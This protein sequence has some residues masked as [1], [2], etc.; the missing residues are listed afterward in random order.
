M[1]SPTS[2]A[3]A[4]P[5][6]PR[7]SW[8]AARRRHGPVVPGSPTSRPST[9][10]WRDVSSGASPTDAAGRPCS[11]GPAAGRPARSPC[12]GSACCSTSRCPRAVPRSRGC[13]VL[14]SHQLARSFSAG[15]VLAMLLFLVAALPLRRRARLAA[16]DVE[17]DRADREP[18]EID[19]PAPLAVPRP[20]RP[21]GGRRKA[22]RFCQWR[23]VSWTGEGRGRGAHSPAH[24]RGADLTRRRG[25][26]ST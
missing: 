12:A 8:P 20:D 2:S 4:P 5:P 21:C 14:L 1:A 11:A 24:H 18:G 23:P 26:S 16:P 22:R 10:R 6:P 9:P 19:G 15:F 13:T 7:R 3:P 25:G 17:G